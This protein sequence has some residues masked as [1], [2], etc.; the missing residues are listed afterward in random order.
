MTTTLAEPRPAKLKPALDAQPALRD[1]AARPET[2]GAETKAPSLPPQPQ[3]RPLPQPAPQ[4]QRETLDP[5]PAIAGAAPRASTRRRLIKRAATLAVAAAALIGASAYGYSWYQ[6]SASHESTDDA[7]IDGHVAPITPRIAGHVEHVYVTDNQEVHAGD[8]LVELDPHDQQAAL[9]AASGKLTAAQADLAAAQS[10][11]LQAEA[12][13]TTAQAQVAQA[14]ADEVAKQAELDRSSLDLTHY[15]AAARSGVVSSVE[16]NKVQ[17]DVRTA[18]ANLDAAKKVVA[19]TQAQ[20]AQAQAT[21]AARQGQVAVAQAQITSAQAA[22][23]TARLNLS[24]TRIVAPTD[25]RITRK[26]VE[27]GEYVA[28]G[29][30]PALFAI[31]QPDV[32]VTAN[33]KETQLAHMRPGEPVEVKVDAYPGTRF[34]GHVDSIQQ[35]SGAYFSLL[36][37]ENATGN[38]VK[39]VQRVPV[40]ITLDDPTQRH[41]LGPGMSVEPVVT[42]R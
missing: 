26:S 10:D 41:L 39:V 25:G 4:P 23:E 16:L 17:T 35:G 34:A 6:Y 5:A 19:A 9:D 3:P 12:G 13:I 21:L 1:A 27:P 32:W 36:P 37:P 38:Y 22:V 24:Y 33:F 11:V 8:V 42:I 31:V 30:M 7:F 29:Q 40:K 18:Q 20:V 28:P 2:R 14:Q 15:A